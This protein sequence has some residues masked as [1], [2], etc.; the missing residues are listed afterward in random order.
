MEENSVKIGSYTVIFPN[1]VLWF[2]EFLNNTLYNFENFQFFRYELTEWFVRQIILMSIVV[3]TLDCTCIR[4]IWTHVKVCLYFTLGH[5][6]LCRLHCFWLC[7]IY[8]VEGSSMPS[9]EDNSPSSLFSKITEVLDSN[10][11][12]TRVKFCLCT[13]LRMSSADTLTYV[14]KVCQFFFF[15]YISIYIVEN[16]T[17]IQ[18]GFLLLFFA[19]F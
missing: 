2:L 3:K 15:H 9:S 10:V 16:K 17:Y 1:K 4:N 14:P 6:Q 18:K 13:W 7:K 12:L 11:R 5:F 19:R 8:A